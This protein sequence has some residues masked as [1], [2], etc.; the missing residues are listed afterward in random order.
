MSIVQNIQRPTGTSEQTVVPSGGSVKADLITA[1]GRSIES[2]ASLGKAFETQ[3]QKDLSPLSRALTLYTDTV[4]GRE[5]SEPEKIDKWNAVYNWALRQGYTPSDI[6]GVAKGV[7]AD[8]PRGTSREYIKSSNQAVTAR[9][10]AFKEA[11]IRN[12]P[13]QPLD[14]AMELTLRDNQNA[15]KIAA[16][17]EG[18]QSKYGVTADMA[19]VDIEDTLLTYM[20]SELNK[21]Y[22]SMGKGGFTNDE[23]IKGIEGVRE[24]MIQNG[25]PAEYLNQLVEITY[26]LWSP[27]AEKELK[28]ATS[29]TQSLEEKKKEAEHVAN[30]TKI[31]NDILLGT[32]KNKAYS[33]KVPVEMKDGST[34]ITN[35]AMVAVLADMDPTMLATV[36]DKVKNP[37]DVYRS[38]LTGSIEEDIPQSSLPTYLSKQYAKAVASSPKTETRNNGANTQMEANKG[39]LRSLSNDTRAKSSTLIDVFNDMITLDPENYQNSTEA[40][41]RNSAVVQ[42]NLKVIGRQFG[43]ELPNSLPLFDS[44][45]TLQLYKLNKD[46]GKIFIANPAVEGAGMLLETGTAYD[47]ENLTSGWSGRSDRAV[48]DSYYATSIP[49]MIKNITTVTGMS[50]KDAKEF[51]NRIVVANSDVG[52]RVAAGKDT[53]YRN[54]I[55]LESPINTSPELP[56]SVASEIASDIVRGKVRDGYKETEVI[57]VPPESNEEFL[58]VGRVPPPQPLPPEEARR[59]PPPQPLPPMEVGRSTVFTDKSQKESGTIDLTS[60][61]VVRNE[62]GSIST[63]YSIIIGEDNEYVL[64]PTV[65]NGRVVSEDEAVEHYHQTGEHHGKYRSIEDAEKASRKLSEIQRKRYMK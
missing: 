65:V 28:A 49:L 43:L 31:R 19:Y 22:S 26:N 17:G 56:A 13:G 62:D 27:L 3:S 40:I 25:I 42:G 32:A 44:T 58:S 10:E 52:K 18:L 29:F 46:T 60:R 34:T 37:V 20:S 8:I 59:V 14:K 54:W 11:A 57:S 4:L 63:E 23:L 21:A 15:L 30:M 50:E 55:S 7:G 38:L 24:Q 5:I 48:F 12:Y 53:R 45:G 36:M 41:E 6:D 35:G 47:V 9:Q 39:I 64:I 2:I 33:T 51:Y 61:A 1:A 16:A